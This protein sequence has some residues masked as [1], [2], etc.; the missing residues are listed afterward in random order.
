MLTTKSEAAPN[1]FEPFRPIVKLLEL[2]K[3]PLS[4]NVTSDP[5]AGDAGK[6]T[7]NAAFT[8]VAD[9]LINN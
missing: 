2:R 3:F 8:P 6:V 5:T 7:V 9:V 1:I 4:I